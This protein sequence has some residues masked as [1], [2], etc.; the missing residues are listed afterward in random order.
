MQQVIISGRVRVTD[1]FIFP[2]TDSTENLFLIKS[3]MVLFLLVLLDMY[4][5]SVVF[6]SASRNLSVQ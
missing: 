1:E 5:N 6:K 3:M 2:L 4:V